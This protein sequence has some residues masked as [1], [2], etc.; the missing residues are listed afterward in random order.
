MT[1][2]HQPECSELNNPEPTNLDPVPLFVDLDGTLIK[3]DLLLESVLS[4]LR[5]QPWMLFAMMYWLALGK[6]KLKEEIAKRT[7]LDFESLPLQQEFL[8]FL[9]REKMSGRALYL[10]TASDRRLAEPIAELLGIFNA[11]LSSDGKSNLK[12]DRKL[13][14]ILTLCNGGDFDYAGNERA[15]LAIWAKA[16]RVIAVNPSTAVIAALRNRR[17]LIQ[18]VFDDRPPP[19]RT[20]IRALRIHQWAKNVLLGV[21]VLTAH[22]FTLPAVAQI[23]VAFT[24]F[25]LVASAN[26]LLNDLIDLT[27]DRH[28]PRKCRRP[29]A[30]G[31]IG[32]AS[33]ALA[34]I[35]AFATGFA[36]AGQLSADFLFTLIVYLFSTISYS[37]YFKR[38]VLIDVLLLASLY[39]LR[40]VSGAYA[41]QV[42][43]SSWLLA[44]SMFLFLS[45]ALVKRSTELIT[46]QRLSRKTARGRNYQVSDYPILSAMGVASGYISILVLALFIS[47]PDIV[48]RY[49]R[50]VVLWLLCPWMAYWVSRLWLKTSRGEMQDDPLMFS[51]KDKASWI[52]FANMMIV[53]LVSI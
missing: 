31:D 53:T 19:A 52:V 44:Y 20:W 8:A 32:L 1:E 4:L 41:I 11:V 5:K 37:L 50:P 45:L 7:N 28:H 38:V 27:S 43:L 36:L 10:A 47:S 12:G 23:T 35:V 34:M 51:L 3:T 2:R 21:P 22:T 49:S 30:A 18:H 46:M 26:Y 15:D 48:E 39:T 17:H 33:G 42:V 6:A 29:L 14:A 9:H 25:G 40:V 13:H 16:R 24:A